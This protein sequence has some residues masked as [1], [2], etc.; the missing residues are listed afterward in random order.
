MGRALK[1]S[2]DQEIKVGRKHNIGKQ[3]SICPRGNDLMDGSKLGRGGDVNLRCTTKA[4]PKEVVLPGSGPVKNRRWIRKDSGAGECP[5]AGSLDAR[6][7]VFMPVIGEVPVHKSTI[8]V[9]VPV[10]LFVGFMDPNSK[11]VR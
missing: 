4:G 3:P 5:M 1:D 10:P 9:I 8:I 6:W 2:L 7:C 11:S